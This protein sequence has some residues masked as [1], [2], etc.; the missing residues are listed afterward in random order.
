MR[1][2][3]ASSDDDGHQVHPQVA[4]VAGVEEHA[5]SPMVTP[6]DRDQ[7]CARSRARGLPKAWPARDRRIVEA[8]RR[9][10]PPSQ[11]GSVPL[12]DVHAH[13]LHQPRRQD[14]RSRA[15]HHARGRERRAPRLVRPCTASCAGAS[16]APPRALIRSRPRVAAQATSGGPWRASVSLDPAAPTAGRSRSRCPPGARTSS[17][18]R[19]WPA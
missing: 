5:R 17:D 4:V 13:V 6:G 8:L 16:S 3:L 10:E 12:G 18:R 1:M 7:Q 19:G 11:S 9:R 15:P 14:A 2:K